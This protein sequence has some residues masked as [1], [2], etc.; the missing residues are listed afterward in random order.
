MAKFEGDGFEFSPIKWKNGRHKQRI[1]K[2]TLT[3]QQNKQK[4][5]PLD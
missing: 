1:G 2:H 4:N 3:R 5:K